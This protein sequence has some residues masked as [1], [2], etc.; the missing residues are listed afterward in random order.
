MNNEPFKVNYHSHTK[1]CGH[2]EGEDEDF[3]K[4]AIKC[5]YKI[6]GFSDHV[7]L[8]KFEQK[9]MRGSYELDFDDYVKSVRSLEKKYKDQIEIHLA[10]EAEWLFDAYDDYYDHLLKDGIVD[11]LIIGQHGYIDRTLNKFIFYASLKDKK[12]AT[13]RYLNDIVAG[14]RSHNFIYAAHPDLY[15]SWYDKWDD[16][17]IEV[18]KTIIKEAKRNNVILELNMGP[19]RWGRKSEG[20]DFT[21]PYPNEDFWYLVKEANAPCIIGIDNHRPFELETTPYDWMRRFVRRHDLQPLER[22]D[23]PFKKSE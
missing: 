12:E 9:G 17:A 13:I 7:M 21:V 20:E 18:A 4:T 2:A 1:R 5:G 16:F 11:Y 14:F 3:V 6:Y 8:P 10:F 15:M 22:L 23:L 19:S